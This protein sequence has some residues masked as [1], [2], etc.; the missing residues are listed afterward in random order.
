MINL[1]RRAAKK[2]KRLLAPICGIAALLTVA[3]LITSCGDD[4][5]VNGSA[6]EWIT[7]FEDDFNSTTLD[8]RWEL[9]EGDASIEPPRLFRRLF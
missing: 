9:I 2:T 1:M 3:F 7:V 8:S 5:S 4:N 6:C